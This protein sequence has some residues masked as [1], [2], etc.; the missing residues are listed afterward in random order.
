MQNLFIYL[1]PFI[2]CIYLPFYSWIPL[3]FWSLGEKR[4]GSVSVSL[5]ICLFLLPLQWLPLP[6]IPDACLLWYPHLGG[7][8]RH[9]IGPFRICGFPDLSRLP[10]WHIFSVYSWNQGMQHF[11]NTPNIVPTY[12]KFAK[13]VE[14]HK[15][16]NDFLNNKKCSF[17]FLYIIF[18]DYR[19][20][21]IIFIYRIISSSFLPFLIFT[22][23]TLPF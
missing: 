10:W 21:P 4:W 23:K 12:R 1:K 6:C 2:V 3:L 20:T 8:G 15:I 9:R 7:P 14:N 11:C 18:Q 13:A 16:N 19:E 17:E 22:T 5:N